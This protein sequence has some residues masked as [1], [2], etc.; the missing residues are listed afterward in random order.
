MTTTTTATDRTAQ[1]EEIHVADNVRAL[2]PEHV[3]ALAGSIRLQGMLV[4]VVV[5]PAQADVALGGWKFELVAGFHR[6]A[7]AAELHLNEIPVVIREADSE[8]AAASENIARKQL[9][10]YEEARAVRAMLDTGLSEDGA[11]QALGWPKQRVTARVRLLELPEQAQQ[12]TGTGVI[13][14]AAVDQLRTVGQVS[15]KL[16]DVLVDH[17]A[18]EPDGWAGRQLA[19]DPARA[20]SEALRHGDSKVFAAYLNTVGSREIEQLRLGKKTA[21]LYAEAEK[22]HKQVDRY[23][24]GPP[25]IRFSE[26]DVDEARAAGVLI[27]LERCEPIIVDRPLYRELAKGAVKRTT[28]QLRVKAAAAKLEKSSAKAKANAG[29]AV[30]PAGE[31]RRE[32]GRALR[33][34]A[35]QAHGANRDLGRGLMNGLA[36]VDPSDINVARLLVYGP[37]GGDYDGSPY[38][39]SGDRVAD[40]A[41]RGIRLVIDEFRT[42]VAKTR[43]DGS[44]GRLRI[45]YGDPRKPQDAVRW[46]FKFLDGARS[47]G[48]LYGRA[49]VV[50]AAEQY[51]CR[52]VLPSTQQ[53]TPHRWPSHNDH[54]RKALAK[55]AAPHLPATL[56]QLE[57]AIAKAHGGYERAQQDARPKPAPVVESDG[58]AYPDDC[59]DELNEP[60]HHPVDDAVDGDVIDPGGAVGPDGQLYSD[61]DPGL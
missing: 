53:V 7:A 10:P 28:E 1:L 4:P 46:L 33:E 24:Y 26:Q 51:A 58:Q 6:V 48:D 61:A 18:T 12:L 19:T 23:A 45:D 13:P 57:K 29:A 55:L 34:L 43:R 52:L 47:A 2:D 38:T 30:D 42:D 27:E 3:R 41:R 35:D 25:T 44:R 49:I 56:K 8:A 60:D 39:S 22:L 17:V 11:A 59:D 54:A 31:A 40:L 14:L 16:L 21:D 36:S 37:L 32:H 5:R 9:N 20:L 15:P 50:L